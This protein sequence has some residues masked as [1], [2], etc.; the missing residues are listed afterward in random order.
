MSL[1]ASW[2]ASPPPDAAVEIASDHVA[3]AVVRERGRGLAVQGYAV[4]PLPAGSVIA[5]LTSTNILNRSAVTAALRT[6]LERADARPRRVALVIPDLAT[7][8]SLVRFETIPSRRED[9]DQLVRWQMKKASPF[10][11]ED[12]SVTFTPGA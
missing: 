12:A 1:F 10:P 11:I 5:S 4:V 2:L 9:L 7:K 3:V 8:A 6:A